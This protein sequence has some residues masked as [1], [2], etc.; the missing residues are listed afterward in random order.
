MLWDRSERLLQEACNSMVAGESVRTAVVDVTDFDAVVEAASDAER[1]LGRVDVLVNS[2]G[3][4]CPPVPIGQYRTEDWQRILDGNLSGVFFC[5]R[6]V[7]PG[8]IAQQYG[9]V[10]NVASMAGKEGN[11]Q[12]TAYSAA[13]AGVIGLTKAL[14]KEVAASGVLV[15][16]VAPGIFATPMRTSAASR[17]L[18][19]K[20]LDRT[21]PWPWPARQASRT[22]TLICAVNR[23]VHRW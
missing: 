8:M 23:T 17:E 20:L 7:L 3:V 16:A 4:T 9:R 5:C 18:V 22:A 21:P 2:A 1:V 15:N 19:G 11:P 12:E 10:V 6:A 14:G 13:K